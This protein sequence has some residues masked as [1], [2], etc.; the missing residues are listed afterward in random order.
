[1]L[2]SIIQREYHSESVEKSPTALAPDQH[3]S[4]LRLAG[5]VDLSH[6]PEG[7]EFVLTSEGLISE[8]GGRWKGSEGKRKVT[9][10]AVKKFRAL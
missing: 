4:D 2:L 9:G 3:L 10:T 6:D 5:I 8:L 7:V 1:M